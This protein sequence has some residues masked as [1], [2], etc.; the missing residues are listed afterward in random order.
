MPP[1]ILGEY[2]TYQDC[3]TTE[4]HTNGQVIR[5]GLGLSEEK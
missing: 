2:P 4:C 1:N 5:N 3:Q